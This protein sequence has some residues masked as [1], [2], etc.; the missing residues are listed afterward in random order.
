MKEEK[1]MKYVAKK[2]LPAI[3]E[4]RYFVDEYEIILN[5]GYTFERNNT[6]FYSQTIKE[7]KRKTIKN[8]SIK[9][10]KKPPSN[11]LHNDIINFKIC[12]YF[13]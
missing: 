13:F 8:R 1:V 3:K 10:I 7:L 4:A 2:Y 6:F 11:I 9:F 12:L 5:R